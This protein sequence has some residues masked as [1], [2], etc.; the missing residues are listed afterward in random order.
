MW[1]DRDR[2]RHTISGS[3]GNRFPNP[4]PDRFVRHF[5]D[6]RFLCPACSFI[7]PF[8]RNFQCC[9]HRLQLA[10]VPGIGERNQTVSLLTCGHSPCCP[11]CFFS[12]LFQGRKLHKRVRRRQQKIPPCQR[13]QVFREFVLNESHLAKCQR[14]WVVDCNRQCNGVMLPG[15]VGKP[16]KAGNVIVKIHSN[17]EEGESELKQPE[18]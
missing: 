5:P 14:C 4:G 17:R 11:A 18:V 13:Q 15:A 3:G 16:C 1:R 9:H 10:D 7:T 2:E 8:Q 12:P 6:P